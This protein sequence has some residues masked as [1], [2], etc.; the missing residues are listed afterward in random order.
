MANR[1]PIKIVANG[2][3]LTLEVPRGTLVFDA[4][5]DALITDLT[6]ADQPFTLIAGGEGGKGN[7]RF[8]SATNQTPRKATPGGHGTKLN[9]RLELKLMADVGLIG[10]P[11]PVKAPYCR[12][13]R[14]HALKLVHTPLPPLSRSLGRSS[15]VTAVSS[16]PIFQAYSKVR[17]EGVGLGH[18]FLRHIERCHLLVHLVDG[19]DGDAEELAKRIG[20]LNDELRRFSNFLASKQ[21]IVALNKTDVRE[22]LPILG[23]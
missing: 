15:A 3:D 7:T 13:Y 23:S 14:G 5:S 12:A 16:W 2:D 18:R 17:R 19:S 8:K 6:E 1:V 20:I 10:F 21:Q 11:T 9:I 22:D 4:D